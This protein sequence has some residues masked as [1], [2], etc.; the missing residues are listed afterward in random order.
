MT[1]IYIDNHKRIQGRMKAVETLGNNNQ[2]VRLIVADNISN[3]L[4]YTYGAMFERLSIVL[5]RRLCTWDKEESRIP[6]GGGGR[7]ADQI[8]VMV[9]LTT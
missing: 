5:Y 2:I 8:H 9:S 4:N 6:L 7:G 1:V 3:D